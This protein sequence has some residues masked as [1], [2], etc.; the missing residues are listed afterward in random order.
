MFHYVHGIKVDV[1]INMSRS[2]HGFECHLEANSSKPDGPQVS[3]IIFF[4]IN[5]LFKGLS[6]QEIEFP[7]K[8][9][10][11][12]FKI[13]SRMCLGCFGWIKSYS[14]LFQL[15]PAT[16][17]PLQ[18]IPACSILFKPIPATSKEV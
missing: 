12:F 6:Q 14:S 15:I 18:H 3:S 1:I 16:S 8:I 13:L 10:G 7:E 17:S 2:L 4:F 9:T 11:G 5:M